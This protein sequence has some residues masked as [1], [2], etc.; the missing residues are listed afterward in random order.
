MCWWSRKKN[1]CIIKRHTTECWKKVKVEI[2]LLPIYLRNNSLNIRLLWHIIVYWIDYLLE[3]CILYSL[4]FWHMNYFSV[5]LM[6]VII[7][8]QFY[9]PYA[10]YRMDFKSIRRA[11]FNFVCRRIRPEQVI[12]LILS[13][14]NDTLGQTE[15][16]LVSFSIGTIYSFKISYFDQDWN[17]IIQNYFCQ[18]EQT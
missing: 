13:D 4:I 11:D 17:R 7:W 15:L 10:A 5:F 2:F 8:I 6:W 1:T 9:Y 14:D 3:Y 18:F 12:S 16:F